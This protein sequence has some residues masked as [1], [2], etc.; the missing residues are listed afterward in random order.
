[1]RVLPVTKTSE[2]LTIETRESERYVELVRCIGVN[3]IADRP[4][5]FA[6]LREIHSRVTRVCVLRVEVFAK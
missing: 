4:R 1:V 5:V 2:L 6:T 3:T